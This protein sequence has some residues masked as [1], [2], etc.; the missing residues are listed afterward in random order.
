MFNFVFFAIGA[1]LSLAATT[2]FMVLG[3][4]WITIGHGLHPF[5][6]FTCVLFCSFSTAWFLRELH[7]EYLDWAF[8]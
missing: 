1:V 7:E 8:T 6:A 3:I 2:F 5:L 4:D